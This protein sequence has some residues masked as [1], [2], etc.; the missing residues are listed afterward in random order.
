MIISSF[1]KRELKFWDLPKVVQLIHFGSRI[2]TKFTL[3]QSYV[4]VA[5]ILSLFSCEVM[6]DF[7]A[8][9]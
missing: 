7:F 5:V 6:S 1:Q 9:S 4:I 3:F 2:E 8:T